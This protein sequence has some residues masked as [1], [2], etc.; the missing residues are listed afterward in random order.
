[1]VYDGERL[2]MLAFP[3]LAALAGEGL[4]HLGKWIKSWLEKWESASKYLMGIWVDSS[5]NPNR[6]ACD[7]GT[8]LPTFTFVLFV[9]GGRR[10]RG[11][12]IRL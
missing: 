9:W 8:A 6:T 11:S 1:M 5:G 10:P 3:F 4:F 7:N 12:E 2:L